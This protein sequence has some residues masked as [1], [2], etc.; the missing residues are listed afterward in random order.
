M[1]SKLLN[2][3]KQELC[4][5]LSRLEMFLRRHSDAHIENNIKIAAVRNGRDIRYVLATRKKDRNFY[6]IK[7]ETVSENAGI[8]LENMF[9]GISV[10]KIHDDFI[11]SAKRLSNGVCSG[12]LI[13][14]SDVA[15]LK[16]AG[17]RGLNYR[18]FETDEIV[19]VSGRGIV[20]VVVRD[21]NPDC[22]KYESD[23]EAIER[24]EIER[25]VIE[26]TDYGNNIVVNACINRSNVVLS[27]F[28]NAKGGRLLVE[29]GTLADKER[30]V[31][32]MVENIDRFMIK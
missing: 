3:E 12:I 21:E 14:S 13:K 26:M 23:K 31:C 24:L 7:V 22:K 29:K 4:I 32:H 2:G 25:S 15:K 16:G 18:Y 1:L 5:D 30:M 20:A 8:Q 19:P 10:Q 6:N 9:D 17:I 11:K 27:V 28:I